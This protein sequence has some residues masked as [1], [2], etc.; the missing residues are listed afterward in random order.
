MAIRQIGNYFGVHNPTTLYLIR[1]YNYMHCSTGSTVLGYGYYGFSLLIS[2]YRDKQ[3]DRT[4]INNMWCIDIYGR[5]PRLT[6]FLV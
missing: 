4:L 3:N 6:P 1:C 5:L 2:V